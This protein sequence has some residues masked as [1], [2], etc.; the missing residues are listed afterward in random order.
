MAIWLILASALKG[1]P[2]STTQCIVGSVIGVAI[3]TPLIG[4]SDWGFSA[5]D[6][7]IVF[8][9]FA[10]WIISPF[11]GFLISAGVYW[12]VRKFQNRAKGFTDF[13]RQEQIAS[14]G[15]AIF[16]I[17]TSLSRGGNDVANAIAPLLSI[18]EFQGTIDL[19]FIVV[20]TVMIPLL[21]G[22]FG[23]ALG[24]IIVGRKVIRT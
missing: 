22:G 12:I 24:L 10:G 3:F 21:I 17:I 6:W 7:S 8:E 20:G 14:Y 19:G 15:L 2:I 5:V 13:E 11:V 1:L 23:I 16:L 4:V 9:I 18:P